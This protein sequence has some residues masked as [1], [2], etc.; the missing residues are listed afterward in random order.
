MNIPKSKLYS[1]KIC[2]QGKIFPEA[3][4]RYRSRNLTSED[5]G[6]H[7]FWK[8]FRTGMVPMLRFMVMSH[9]STASRS[10]HRL[11]SL[12]PKR[13]AWDYGVTMWGHNIRTH[14]TLPPRVTSEIV[15]TNA[16][17]R[18]RT[19]RE[20][21]ASFE[22]FPIPSFDIERFNGSWTDS[23]L[24]WVSYFPSPEL[25]LDV[26]GDAEPF[27]PIRIHHDY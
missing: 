2:P 18:S 1:H 7:F 6:H 12:C 25:E 17:D 20:K 15:E 23:S 9:I 10:T 11:T 8:K 13:L 21:E 14:A 16:I 3:V 4:F 5:F 19:S 22:F 24:S 27:Q 26:I